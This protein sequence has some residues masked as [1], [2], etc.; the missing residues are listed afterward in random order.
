ME[1]LEA[2]RAV[3]KE[4][5]APELETIKG[6]LREIKAVLLQHDERIRNLEIRTTQQDLRLDRLNQEIANRS[7][8]LTDR[9]DRMRDEL[10]RRIEG[11]R[12]ELTE[13]IEGV[14]ARLM[15]QYGAIT[16][17]LDAMNARLDRLSPPPKPSAPPAKRG[18]ARGGAPSD[19][20]RSRS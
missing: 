15:A 5:I 7:D 6:D 11:V 18:V 20:A 3:F 19:R 9:M 1:V 4:L 2:V 10:N 12:V 13:K 14:E 16:D 17:R 8:I